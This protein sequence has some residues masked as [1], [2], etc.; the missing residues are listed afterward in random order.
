MKRSVINDIITESDAFMRSFGFI[1]PPFAYLSPEAF[2]AHVMADGAMIRDHM[3]G[4]DITDYGQGNYEDLGLFLFTVRNGSD[5]NVS[6][7]MG[8]LYA[9]KM[10]I[11][12]E[13]QISPMHRHIKKTEDIIHFG[14][15]AVHRDPRRRDRRSSRCERVNRRTVAHPQSG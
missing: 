9:E 3:M 1:M 4:W 13:N 11:S 15:R 6:A 7:G 5:A 2:K 12:N 8:M 10:L 14:D